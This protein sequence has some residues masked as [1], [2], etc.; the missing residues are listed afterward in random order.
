MCNFRKLRRTK[1]KRYRTSL[2]RR[3]EERVRWAVKSGKRE[4]LPCQC[5]TRLGA[6]CGHLAQPFV[7]LANKSQAVRWCCRIHRRQL[8]LDLGLPL[9]TPK[10]VFR[11]R[12]KR[13]PAPSGLVIPVRTDEEWTEFYDLHFRL[14]SP[15]GH[16]GDGLPRTQP[17]AAEPVGFWD[18]P[19]P[20]DL[21]GGPSGSQPGCISS[22][23]AVNDDSHS[24]G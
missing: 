6:V 12:R 7:S 24:S 14:G 21:W 20:P 15:V 23:G 5:L 10:Y 11:P 3:L 9:R 16:S 4:A 17:G 18:L 22:W 1:P 8:K 2:A 13:R 19:G